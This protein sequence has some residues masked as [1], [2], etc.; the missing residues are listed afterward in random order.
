MVR[1]G[2]YQEL[3]DKCEVHT[4]PVDRIWARSLRQA[5]LE[6]GQ[7]SKGW[8]ETNW[9]L[10]FKMLR[11]DLNN[12]VERIDQV[13]DWYCVHIR[14]EY[15]PL[16]LSAKAFREK[17]IR[18]EEAMKRFHKKNPQ[19]EVGK[20]AAEVVRYLNRH[21]WPKDAAARLP[22]AVQ[23]S[24]DNYTKFRDRL[25][26]LTDTIETHNGKVS[27]LRLFHRVVILKCSKPKDFVLSWMENVYYSVKDWSAWNADI[28]SLAF[29]VDSKA[30]QKM[31]AGWAAQYSGKPELW[32]EYL[33]MLEFLD[34]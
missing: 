30:F 19:V 25:K 2:F 8:S 23:I 24:L 13:M 20:D 33:K 5:V 9:V 27:T 12:D 4:I 29:T 11:Q 22:I 18:I 26:R 31:G 14:T 7:T 15:V 28:T 16:A 32:Q 3:E 17:F 6:K 21:T 1:R 10:S 34:A